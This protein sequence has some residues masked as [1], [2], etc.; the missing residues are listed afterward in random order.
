MQSSE[1]SGIFPRHR[2]LPRMPQ[3]PLLLHIYS[4]LAA[5]LRLHHHW[6]SLF[7]FLSFV[8][9]V[10]LATGT[11]QSP[12]LPTI[13]SFAAN[14]TLTSPAVANPVS[15]LS[16]AS[17]ATGPPA[18]PV[19]LPPRTPSSRAGRPGFDVD[20]G[21]PPIPPK[22]VDQIRNAEYVQFAELLPDSLRDNEVPRELLL[23]SR[24]VAIP[25]RPPRREVKD[26]MSWLGCWIAY[27]QVVLA[28]FP[29]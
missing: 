2:L 17:F 15:P 5:H 22:L 10:C 3:V 28:F 9:T 14:I 29:S 7:A 25:K 21:R 26:I 23:E 20:P 6:V 13:A 18:P 8:S 1:P 16:P 11:P 24:Q 4:P 27:C 19:P 12:I